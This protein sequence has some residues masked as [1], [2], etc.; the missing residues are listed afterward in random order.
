MQRV[1]ARIVRPVSTLLEILALW[2]LRQEGDRHTV[3]TLLEI[4]ASNT[5]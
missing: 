2:H 5:P 3:S 4:L 1:S